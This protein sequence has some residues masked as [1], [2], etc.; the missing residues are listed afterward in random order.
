MKL[1]NRDDFMKLPEGI[2]YIS[3]A[4]CTVMEEALMRQEPAGMIRKGETL[5][6]DDG[7]PFDWLTKDLTDI[8][9]SYYCAGTLLENIQSYHMEELESRDGAFDTADLFMVYEYLDLLELQHRVEQALE[10]TK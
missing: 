8:N 4:K 3:F 5:F 7:T 10:L 2:L 1:Y 6:R 9:Y